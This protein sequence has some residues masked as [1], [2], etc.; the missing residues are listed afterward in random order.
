MTDIHCHILPSVDDGSKSWEMT[1]EMCRIAYSDGIRHIVA[2]P[3]ANHRYPYDRAV[4]AESL[5]YLREE[6][7]EIEF[8]LGCDFHLSTDNIDNAIRH[9][10]R[11]AIGN[12]PY[13]L[14]EFGDFQMP[15]QMTESIFRLQSAGFHIIVTHP[16]RN[17]VIEENPDISQELFDMGAALQITAGS[18][19]GDFGRKAKKTCEMLLKRNLVGIISSDA[20][21]STRRKPVLSAARTAAA[22]ILGTQVAADLL[23]R[24]NPCAVLCS[25]ALT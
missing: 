6:V 3:H 16:E 2:T 1:F 5:A 10:E 4:H 18:V 20:H 23:V 12:T 24:T 14:V 9:P 15:H 7:P 13:L 21:D 19:T 8:I 17:P 11:Y 25:Q 22:K